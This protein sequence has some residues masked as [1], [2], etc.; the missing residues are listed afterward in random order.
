MDVSP[1]AIAPHRLTHC[2]ARGAAGCASTSSTIGTQ[3][4]HFNLAVA[5]EDLEDFDAAIAAYERALRLDGEFADA[6]YN[7]AMLLEKRGD[8][9][10]AL[11]HFNAYRRLEF[12]EGR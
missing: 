11:R 7:L 4:I 6:H 10:G 3:S 5:L 9:V 2:G 1:I 12:R 8:G